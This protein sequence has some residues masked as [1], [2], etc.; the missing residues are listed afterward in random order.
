MTPDFDT[1]K[2]LNQFQPRNRSNLLQQITWKRRNLRNSEVFSVDA[3]L[4]KSF[5]IRPQTSRCP[6]ASKLKYKIQ[7]SPLPIF[8]TMRLSPPPFQLCDTFF[9]RFFVSKVR[10]LKNKFAGFSGRKL[11]RNEQTAY[12]QIFRLCFANFVNYLKKS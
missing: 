6:K 1:L 11:H 4:V 3:F 12:S 8:G 5:F 10:F 2:R 9:R 7:K